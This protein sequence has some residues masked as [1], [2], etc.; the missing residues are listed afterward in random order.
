MSK[1]HTGSGEASSARPNLRN[2]RQKQLPTSAKPR[3]ERG[4]KTTKSPWEKEKTRAPEPYRFTKR[5]GS[6]TF[7]VNAYSSMTSSETA[8]DKIAKLIK[9]DAVVGKAVSQ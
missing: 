8:S 5:L 6:T 9:C 3:K 2:E 7:T 4:M 1:Q